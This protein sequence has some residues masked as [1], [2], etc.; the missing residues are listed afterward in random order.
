MQPAQLRLQLMNTGAGFIE[1]EVVT[2]SGSKLGAGG[3]ADLTFE[4]ALENTFPTSRVEM[5][6][7]ISITTEAGRSADISI[8]QGM[9]AGQIAEQINSEIGQSGVKAIASNRLEIFD[10]PNGRIQF[11]LFGRN[12]EAASIDLE[13]SNNDIQGACF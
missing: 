7:D 8:T 11:D 3:S 10:L 2:I 13:I 12:S 1:G 5:P 6:S 9:M 4:I